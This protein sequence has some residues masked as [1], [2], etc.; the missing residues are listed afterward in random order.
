MEG[1]D[2]STDPETTMSKFH[3]L[4]MTVLAGGL[5]VVATACGSSGA[6][7]ATGPQGATG[8]QGPQ[9]SQGPTGPQGPQGPTGNANVLVDT[10]TVTNTQWLYNAQYSLETSPGSYTEYFTRYYDATDS[11]VTADILATGMV[12]V[13]FT[14]NPIVSTTQWISL[15]YQFTDF[16]GSFAYNYAYETSVDHVA[17]EFFFVTLNSTNPTPSLSTFD[18]PTFQFKIVAVSGTVAQSLKVAHIDLGNADAVLRFV[19]RFRAI[20]SRA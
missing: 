2:T 15:P 17:L 4:G 5:I 3:T 14:P 10:F 18:I 13:Y 1:V 6:T 16:S 12:L 9:G 19:S 8:A 7:G 11:A 20:G